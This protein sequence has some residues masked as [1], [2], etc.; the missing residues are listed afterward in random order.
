MKKVLYR[1][2]LL[3]YLLTGIAG[4]LLA[5][6]AGSY[7]IECRLEK[8]VSEDLYRE[9]HRIASDDNIRHNISSANL[10]LVRENLSVAA[11]Y[12][13]SI[14]WILNNSGEIVLSTR[15]D[16]SPDEPIDLSTFDPTLW[17]GNYYQIGDFYGYFSETRLSVIAPITE[18]MN[19]KGY[20][21]IHYLMSD[22]YQDRS[23]LLGVLL[24]LL[25]IFYL[26]SGLLVVFYHFS[27]QRPLQHI[28]KGAREYAGGNLSY[29]I[30]LKSDD[31]IGYLAN[32]LNYMTDKLNKTGEYQRKF[33]SNVSHDFRSPLTSI[34]GYVN[35]MLD[36]T[37]PPEMQEKYLKIIA[38][39][40]GRLEKLTNSLLTLNDLDIKKRMMHI[41]KFDINEVVKTTAAT[42]EGIC[43]ERKILLELVL[44]GKELYT[45]AD[46]EQIQQVLYNLLDN[47]IKFSYDGSSIIIETTE[48]NDKIFVSVKDRGEGIPKACLS[49][50]WDRFYKSDASR[51][52]DRK[53]T[54]L[55]LSI[56]QEIIHAHN[57]NINVISTEGVGTEFIFTLDKVR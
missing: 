53:G 54:G 49:K 42:F 17:G 35:A 22:L 30:P 3:V 48:K 24:L 44:S 47:A 21:C 7:M 18:N 41:R 25:G 26:L 52:K 11:E 14:I 51:G 28:I 56:V 23:S 20:V 45:K 12:Q 2:F 39:E 43:T 50:I 1:R 9:A 27:V 13:N 46:M 55:G 5:T 34:K 15:K 40:A 57:Q 37:I 4:L 32:T 38:Y 33:I 16:I 19:T 31:E 10:D 8:A 36:G 29:R 6:T